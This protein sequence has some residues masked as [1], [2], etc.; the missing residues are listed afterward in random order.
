M[1]QLHAHQ[2]AAKRGVCAASLYA[3]VAQSCKRSQHRPLRVSSCV[4]KLGVVAASALTSPGLVQPPLGRPSAVIPGRSDSGRLK[5]AGPFIAAATEQPSA[6]VQS[7]DPTSIDHPPLNHQ[8]L[9]DLGA[10]FVKCWFT[11]IAKGPQA[12]E[13][14]LSSI[15]D[16][17]ATLKGDSVRLLEDQQGFVEVLAELERAHL[18]YHRSEHRPMLYAASEASQR[19]YA[20]VEGR[21]QDVGALPGHPA[22]F[23]I[24]KVHHI[25]S[26]LVRNG[27]VEKLWL[28]RQ[29]TEEDKDELLHD[30]LTCYPAPFPRDN[31]MLTDAAAHELSSEKLVQ[32]V[33]AWWTAWSTAPPPPPA[34]V[35]ATADHSADS[36]Y[37]SVD[38]AASASA[39]AAYKASSSTTSS[40]S[41]VDAAESGQRP[42]RS[43]RSRGDPPGTLAA[44]LLAPTY[45]MWDAYGLWPAMRSQG[46][47]HL[48]K[49]S[50][51][52]YLQQLQYSYNISW[53][54]VDAAVAE[55]SLACFTHWQAKF[56]PKWG[57][58]PAPAAAVAAAIAKAAAPKDNTA[59][60][61]DATSS[62]AEPPAV[63][64]AARADSSPSL[65]QQQQAAA[66]VKDGS[67]TVDGLEVDMFNGQ[68]Q[69]QAT[70][71]FRGPITD[72]E[73]KL[74]LE[75]DR[76][77][78]AAEAA[79]A[80][81]EQ[82]SIRQAR[83]EQR[84]QQLS[85]LVAW[86]N[87]YQQQW[88]EYV[89]HVQ[90]TLERQQ[91][92]A[93][94]QIKQQVYV[95]DQLQQHYQKLQAE[96]KEQFEQLQQQQQHNKDQEAAAAAETS[97]P[98]SPAPKERQL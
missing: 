42:R 33:K 18:E 29:L 65:P 80:E 60:V 77:Q 72:A 13:D 12:V 84:E 16:E 19:V 10:T 38:D 49:E 87:Q 96:Q 36:S 62:S 8:Q 88:G 30:P 21:Y 69:L 81:S 61:E 4:N 48:N 24:S 7:L 71:L 78:A 46:R 6:V 51:V 34:A 55:G 9:L 31:L 90:K 68:L 47:R 95:V 56:E 44:H 83:R 53:Q 70:W 32:F 23:R 66:E 74:F 67:F 63:A 97:N 14:P 39:R 57:A 11:G 37:G 45:K 35:A 82:E 59:A 25:I 75:Y 17:H 50:A 3:P 94:A 93:Q 92:L 85:E 98:P 52:H 1:K 89:K 76:Q 26:L 86:M 28:R 2:W 22:T 58:T 15:I 27:R 91:Q 64:P 5:T 73:T 54:V 79:Q 40:S 20:L 41:S 43:L